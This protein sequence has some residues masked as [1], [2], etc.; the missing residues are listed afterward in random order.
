MP[1]EI[2]RNDITN[3]VVDA[4]VN[5]ANPRP[6]VGSGVD[7]AIHQK[8]G[9]Q[10]LAAREQ[11]G[12]IPRGVCAIT[13]AFGL[14]AKYVIHAVGPKWKG[15]TQ[16]EEMLLRQCYENALRLAWENS[17][18][19]I[20][21]PSISTGNYGFPKPLA[22]R[23]AIDTIENFL[24]DHDMDVYLVVFSKEAFRLSGEMFQSVASFIDDRYVELR[25]QEEYSPIRGRDEIS[26]SFMSC[27]K[28]SDDPDGPN[29]DPFD[30]ILKIFSLDKQIED[31]HAGWSESLLKLIDQSG[32]T[33][34][35]IY[36]KANVT[37]KH[38]SKIRNDPEY[39]PT[40]Q[41]AIA[42]AVALNLSYDE[43]QEF[44]GR[45]GYML[46]RSSISDIVVEYFLR[47][48]NYNII[49]LNIALFEYGQKT[50]N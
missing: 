43:T 46:T 38:F 32:K 17:C 6:I 16:G 37:A 28:T 4:V 8:A 42:F 25:E 12:Y 36:K 45:A 15:G 22:L 10:L 21:F 48:Q 49:E 23:I 34:P 44:I 39:K 3:M 9:P 47:N 20:A 1:F 18:Q 13:P 40:K 26:G 31:K 5:T 30:D 2:V 7:T 41:T 24:A 14:T 27:I 33:D 29:R 11:I 19:S 35:E 50:L